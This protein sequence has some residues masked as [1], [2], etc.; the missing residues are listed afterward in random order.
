VVFP[1][2]TNNVNT[3]LQLRDGE[4]QI[5]GGLIQHQNDQSQT[6][7]P[8]FGDLPLIGR[9]FGSVTDT[10]NKKE[11]VLAITP[12]IVRNAPVRDADMVELWSGTEGRIRYGAPGL[13]VSGGNGV[14][15]TQPTGPAAAVPLVPAVPVV[16]PAPAA[17]VR[18]VPVL[19]VTPIDNAAA[20]A[21]ESADAPPGGA[22]Q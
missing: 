11:L 6:K 21:N 1:I 7:I 3:L 15:M 8:G 12:H 10:W 18:P 22:A 4:T 20:P 13:K 16:A 9:L 5:L 19:P 17:I 2:T 14:M